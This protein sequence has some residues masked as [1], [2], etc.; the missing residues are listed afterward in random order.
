[1]TLDSPLL[2]GTPVSTLR[3][4]EGTC[5]LAIHTL[6]VFWGEKCPKICYRKMFY[7]YNL[8]I[9]LFLLKY[10]INLLEVLNF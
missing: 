5:N 1:M 7:S 4:E 8:I 6:V 3:S 2:A 10:E 9:L